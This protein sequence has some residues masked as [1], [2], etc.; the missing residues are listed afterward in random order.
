MIRLLGALMLAGGVASIGFFA[1][2][3]LNRRTRALRAICGAL[4]RMEQEIAFRLTPLPDLFRLL[5]I[6]SEPPARELFARCL[7]GLERLG[8]VP[9]SQ[10]WSEELERLMPYLRE[11]ERGALEELGSVLGRY[12]GEAQRA[13]LSRVRTE[14]AHG[15]ETAQEE[16]KQ[17]G[18]I[19]R[20]LGITAGAFF[21]ILLL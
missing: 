21:V 16:Q 13:A 9:F 12:D 6:Q 14:L 4:E 15:L 19:Y 8:E 18:R 5:S 7:E 10:I 1:A 20:V 11:G 17:Q 3:E 2:G